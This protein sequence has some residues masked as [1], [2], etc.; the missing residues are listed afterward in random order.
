VGGDDT[1][2]I[3]VVCSANQ[4][5]S[6]MTEAMLARRAREGDLPLEVASMGAQASLGMPATPPTI[7]AARKLGVD[8]TEHA[9]TPLDATVVRR[10][11]LVLGLERRHVQ[12]VVVA[13]PSA[14]PRSFTLK[15]FVRRGTAIG[16]RAP[17]EPM[18]E[19]LAKL[20]D[21][22]RPTD[23][24]GISSDDDVADP[25]GSKATDHRATAEE[26]DA[27]SAEVLTLVFGSA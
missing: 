26:I 5:R 10:A 18:S 7:D 25:T 21:G 15:E 13:D 1:V 4:C 19:W 23:L 8:L 9:S 11:D 6:P 27:L 16:G 14:F 12:D 24:L 20:H 17:G 3:L 22:R 2:R